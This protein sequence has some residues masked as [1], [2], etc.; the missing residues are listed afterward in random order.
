MSTRSITSHSTDFGRVQ[1]RFE[2]WRG[3]RRPGTR[4]PGDLWQ[5]A[6]DLARDI[7]VSRTAHDL[8]LDYYA[9]KDRVQ[10]GPPSVP[11]VA[12]ESDTGQFIEIP[13]AAARNSA[14]CVLEIQSSSDVRVRMELQ[15]M[16]GAELGSLVRSVMGA[17][18]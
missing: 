17:T 8:R 18:G 15:G 12:V 1:R 9:L 16:D 5:A 14:A 6:V 10:A 3:R 11:N 2:R 7:G 4:I 13:V